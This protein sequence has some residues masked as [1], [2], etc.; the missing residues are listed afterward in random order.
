MLRVVQTAICDDSDPRSM[1]TRQADQAGPALAECG[2]PGFV[3]CDVNV[4]DTCVFQRSKNGL[5]GGF[6]FSPFVCV[7][8][9]LAL[10]DSNTNGSAPNDSL[11]GFDDFQGQGDSI[12]YA[13]PQRSVL[14][15]V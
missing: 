13:S 7:I 11:Y 1:T 3:F 4:M 8:V 5:S 6:A 2:R 14:W 15:F 12:P 9:D 10:R